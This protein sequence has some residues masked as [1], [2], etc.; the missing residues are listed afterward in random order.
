[1]PQQLFCLFLHMHGVDGDGVLFKNGLDQA[2]KDLR[3]FAALSVKIF[4]GRADA[5][6]SQLLCLFLDVDCQHSGFLPR[7]FHTVIDVCM[8]VLFVWVHDNEGMSEA[9]VVDKHA[10]Q[11][12]CLCSS[13]ICDSM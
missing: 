6:I 1:M 5:A 11:G 13:S 9:F 4:G 2:S 7:C 12:V 8:W 3:H 10:T